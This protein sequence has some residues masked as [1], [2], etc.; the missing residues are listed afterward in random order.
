VLNQI[1]IYT[2]NIL[3]LIETGLNYKKGTELQRIR[4]LEI[5]RF[6]SLI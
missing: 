2:V 4:F 5:N 3:K 6:A 1:R